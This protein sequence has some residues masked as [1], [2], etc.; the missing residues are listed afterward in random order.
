MIRYFLPLFF[1]SNFAVASLQPVE[2]SFEVDECIKKFKDQNIDCLD[3]AITTSE[4]A[5]NS[6]YQKKL[7]EIS[8]F[9]PENWWMG[10]KEQKDEML[11]NFKENQRQWISYRDKYCS[12]AL[13]QYQNSNHLGEVQTSCELNMNKRRIDEIKMFSVSSD[14]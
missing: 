10:N 12:I 5:L 14:D 13:T 11:K 6:T 8:N 3:K 1:V 4:N 2:N 7:N 9:N